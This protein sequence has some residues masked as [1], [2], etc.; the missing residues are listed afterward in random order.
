LLS[1]MGS[2]GQARELVFA[3]VEGGGTT[4]VAAIAKG[5]PSNVVQREVFPTTTPSETFEK[6]VGWLRA[7]NQE[8][9]F[10]ALGIASFGPVDLD[11][12]SPTYGYIT[13]TP[14][15]K[16]GSTPVLEHFK[17]FDCPKGFDTDV[18]GAATSEASLGGHRKDKKGALSSCA[19]I[20]VGT[21]VGVGVVVNGKPVHGLIHPEVGHV[22]PPRHPSDTAF[23]G[24]CPYHSACVEGLVSSGALSSRVGIPAS[25]LASLPDDHPVWELIGFYLAHLCVNIVL[26]I[27]PEVIVLGGG[28]LKREI[29]YRIVRKQ[30]A[31]LL[32]GYI[33]SPLL[34][35]RID[36]FIVQSPFGSNSGIVGALELGRIALFESSSTAN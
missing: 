2:L 4:F 9:K 15:P 12:H 28:V 35:E 29:L 19:Y 22:S 3:G 36:E 16:W 30:T 5:T 1:L 27:S 21:G 20:T 11:V 31:Q 13:T 10:D 33:S 6:V 23:K 24:T 8:A 14:K 26:T 17:E 25:E 18:N 32:N 7:R 34:R